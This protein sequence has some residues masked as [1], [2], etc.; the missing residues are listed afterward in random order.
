M[1]MKFMLA[2]VFSL[3]VLAFAASAQD[4]AANFSGTW[5]LD[6]AKSK[7]DER[8]HIESQTLTVTQTD[9]D[10]KIE[11][12]TKHAPPPVDKEKQDGDKS[13]DGARSG[14]GRR[15]GGM[16]GGG[17][18]TTTY[19]LD[20][21]ET[22]T[23]VQGPMGTMPVSLKARLRSGKL[24]LGRNSTL[25]GR[26]GEVSVSSR[27]VW[28]LSADGTTLTVNSERT[29]PRGTNSSTMVYTKRS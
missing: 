13:G 29:S 8:A 11:T 6:V 16:M 24:E 22:K 15:R 14:G 27:E 20:G 1:K 9:K 12:A 17:D 23:E 25:N 19:S 26:M 5:N 28:E 18:G 4:K 10:I 2:A 21:K 3:F 7:L